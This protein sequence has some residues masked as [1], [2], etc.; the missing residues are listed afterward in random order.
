MK[1]LRLLVA[2]IA[3]VPL[4]FSQSGSIDQPSLGQTSVAIWNNSSQR[5]TFEMSGDGGQSWSSFALD[6]DAN[7][8]YKNLN[9]IRISTTRQDGTSVTK[10]YNLKWSQRYALAHNDKDN[11]WDVFDNNRRD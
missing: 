5:L 1:V 6:P 3:V 8:Q 7:D 9:L 4:A 10:S 11:C 2:I